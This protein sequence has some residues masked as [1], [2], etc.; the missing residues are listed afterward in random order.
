M[1]LS[2]PLISQKTKGKNSESLLHPTFIPAHPFSPFLHWMSHLYILAIQSRCWHLIIQGPPTP[3]PLCLSDC[4]TISKTTYKS[5]FC[6]QQ[7]QYLI[8][9]LKSRW[10]SSQILSFLLLKL[11]FSFTYWSNLYFDLSLIKNRNALLSGN[12]FLW[13]FLIT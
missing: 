4:V 7:W 5:W 6:V 1:Q 2:E 10:H 3:Y 8:I 9:F 11:H 13:S 12:S